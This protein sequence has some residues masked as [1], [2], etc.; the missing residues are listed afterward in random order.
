MTITQSVPFALEATGVERRFPLPQEKLFGHRRYLHAV[1][2]IDVRVEPGRTLGVV[3]ESGCGKST[4]G[5]VL[6]GLD[7][8]DAGTIRWNGTPAGAHTGAVQAVFQDPASALNPRRTIA[9]AIGEALPRMSRSAR[10]T[11]IGELMGMVD[12]DPALMSR[13]PH[14]LS[15]GQQ[16]RVCI[17]RAIASDPALILLDEAVSSLDASLQMQVIELLRDLQERTGAAFIFISHDLRAV[18]G[19]SDWIA[20]MYLGQIVEL[21]PADEFD[22][23]LR[24]P[25]SVALRSAEPSI[26]G[27]EFQPER[28]ILEGDPPSAVE[29]PVGCRFASRCPVAQDRCRVEAP[30]LVHDDDGRAV[31]CHFPGSLQ[32]ARRVV[33]GADA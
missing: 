5:R 30:E 15:G 31:R 11:R 1:D 32:L 12:L 22:D 21:A 3:G 8:A 19:I 20:V 9:Q 2:G 25:Y 18:R 23:Q 7:K 16:Q 33:E 6:V 28:I 10:T 27:D 17:A 24:H 13:Y 4:L 29:R 26:P 14:E